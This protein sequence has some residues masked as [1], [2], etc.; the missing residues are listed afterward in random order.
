METSPS[1]LQFKADTKTPTINNIT[2]SNTS[3]K[4]LAF[5]VKTN[6]P[7]VY[8][9]KPNVSVLD[10]NSTVE[11]SIT[12]PPLK[13]PLPSGYKSKHKFLIMS[14]PSDGIASSEIASNWSLLQSKYA[15]ALQLNKIGVSYSE[16]AK[17]NGRSKR[18]SKFVANGSADGAAGAGAAGAAAAVGAAG[19]AGLAA[20]ANG[21]N[22][23][24]ARPA[25]A[26][27]GSSRTGP[28]ARPGPGVAAGA[29]PRLPADEPVS[30]SFA[31][32]D[33]KPTDSR[34]WQKL[35]ELQHQNDRLTSKLENIE[36]FIILALLIL[37]FI[38]G[39]LMV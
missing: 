38:L 8:S 17:L 31:S 36:K 15:L 19:A 21:A 9:V 4:P 29:G 11:I 7:K 16:E 14:V 5:K 24:L 32:Y 35:Q 2:L 12:L 34:V 10:P 6:A 33:D 22:G 27:N 3:S 18:I 30:K 25:A 37:S 39:K 23:S 1:T 20:A 26:R 28:G 13:Q